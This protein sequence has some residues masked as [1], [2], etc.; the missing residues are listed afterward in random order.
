[1]PG[2]KTSSAFSAFF[3]PFSLARDGGDH[4]RNEETKKKKKEKG[5]ERARKDGAYE[6]VQAKSGYAW[7]VA[8]YQRPQGRRAPRKRSADCTRSLLSTIIFSRFSVVL[9]CCP[10]PFLTPLCCFPFFYFPFFLFSLFPLLSTLAAVFPSWTVI[11][12]FVLMANDPVP[13]TQESE[14]RFRCPFCAVIATRRCRRP[15]A[16]PP[17]FCFRLCVIVQERAIASGDTLLHKTVDRIR[18]HPKRRQIGR[19]SKRAFADRSA[20]F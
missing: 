19:Q 15:A 20:L 5:R 11:G 17:D 3:F 13:L 14:I 8:R 4:A 16:P 12:V 7:I 1:M 2:E 6:Y 10:W 9:F 18:R